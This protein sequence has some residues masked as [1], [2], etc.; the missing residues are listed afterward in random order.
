MSKQVKKS[1]FEFLLYINNKNIICQRFFDME[2]YN[3]ECKNSY[4]LKELM[5]ELTGLNINSVGR[6][7]IIPNFLKKQSIEYLWDTFNPHKIQAESD[8]FVQNI[9]EKIDNFQFEIKVDGKTIATS[10]FSGNYFPPKIRYQVY[11]KDII[12]EIV[13]EIKYYLSMDSYAKVSN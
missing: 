7:G 1:R 5:D 8:I 13:N 10:M 9:F 3:E 4:E 2:N 12:P 11:I 6:L